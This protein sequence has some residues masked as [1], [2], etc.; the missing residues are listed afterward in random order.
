VNVR[1]RTDGKTATLTVSDNGKGFDVD[2]PRSTMGLLAM[3]ERAI[4]INGTL[5]L[6]S[7][8]GEGTIIS[9][10]ATIEEEG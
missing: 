1:V 9:V 2:Q 5:D 8:L 3:R 4:A 7:K 6:T 10:T